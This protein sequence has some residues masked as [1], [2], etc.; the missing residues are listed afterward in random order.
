MAK[1]L[2]INRTDYT[3][4][5]TR[6]GYRVSYS[7]VS[8]RN[9]GWMLDGTY[10]EDEMSLK[11]VITLTCWPL[12][13]TQLSTLLSEIYS[14]PYHEVYYFD[15][16]AGAYRTIEARRAVSEQKYRGSGADGVQYWTGTVVTLTE[17]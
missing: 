10:T 3:D 12:N 4:Y 9:A 5:F 15:P 16:R 13:E 7:P 6:E 2:K 11:A 17:R 1:T 14:Y 8:G